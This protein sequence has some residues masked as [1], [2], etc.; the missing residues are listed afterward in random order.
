MNRLLP[1][2]IA[3]VIAVVAFSS[4]VFVVRERD[5]ALVFALGEVKRVISEPGLYFKLPPP[6]QNVVTLDK[7]LL[8]IDLQEAERIQ[9]SEKKNLLID[10]FV[11]WRVVDPR[12]YYVTFGGNE[13]AARER[14][15][16]QIRDA[17]NASVNVRTVKDVVSLERDVI[18][19]EVLTNV[20]KRAEGLGVQIVDVR[21]KRIEFAPEIAESVYR[22]MESER[23]RVANEQRSIGAAEGEKIRA[24]ADRQRE[25]IVAEAY[26]RAQAIMGEGDAQ[27]AGIYAKAYG[28]DLGFYSFYKSLEGYKASFGKPGD[29]LVVDPSSDF[30][31]YLKSSSGK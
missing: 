20:A 26:G 6:L 31:K 8:T 7:R 29:V 9:T 18:M 15:Q 27:A 14:L 21:L 5:Y 22:R 17:L 16:A 19:Q 4:S 3:L 11:K 10:S 25:Q 13:R 24:E 1:L 2:L 23:I 28:E 12:L 30:F